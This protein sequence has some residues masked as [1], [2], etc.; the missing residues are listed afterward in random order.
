[1]EI[2]PDRRAYSSAREASLVSEECLDHCF[3]IFIIPFTESRVS[4]ISTF[5]YEVECW[6]ELILVL[7]PEFTI[8]VDDNWIDDIFFFYCSFYALSDCFIGRFW[9]MDTD[10]DESLITV[11]LIPC[12]QIGTSILTVKT[13]K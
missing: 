8:I 5:I 10:D 1:M 4:D 7:I 9:S 13:V 11:F 2:V 12:I 6:S 3:T